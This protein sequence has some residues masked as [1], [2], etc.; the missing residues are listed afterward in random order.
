M[1][2]LA[3]AVRVRIESGVARAGAGR[4]QAGVRFAAEAVG[5]GGGRAR[6]A[7]VVAR[8]ARAGSRH[9]AARGAHAHRAHRVVEGRSFAGSAVVQ[10]WTRTGVAE[11]VATDTGCTH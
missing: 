1:A 7:A 5:V 4:L 6:L 3:V 2:S 8:C 10:V 11:G 9:E